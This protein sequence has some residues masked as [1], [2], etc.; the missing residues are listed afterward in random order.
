MNNHWLLF[1]QFK[2]HQL[3]DD[4]INLFDNDINKLLLS[5]KMIFTI[6]IF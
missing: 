6:L 1:A 4:V 2:S 3:P 5:V